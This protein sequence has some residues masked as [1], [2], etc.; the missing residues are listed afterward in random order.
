M[1]IL[2]EAM[3]DRI[4]HCASDSLCD[5]SKP[6]ISMSD[7]TVTQSDAIL[8][9]VMEEIQED[10]CNSDSNRKI[11]KSIEPPALNNCPATLAYPKGIQLVLSVASLCFSLFLA[12]LDQTIVSTTTPRIAAEFNSLSQISWIGTAYMLMSTTFQPLYGK[13]SD[14]FGRKK[15]LLFAMTMFLSGSVACG[16]S[17]SMTMLIVWRAIAGVGGGGLLTTSIVGLA[18]VVSPDRRDAYMGFFGG[19]WAFSA[20]I[21]PV[22][23]GVFVDHLNWRWAFYINLT[24]GLPTIPIFLLFA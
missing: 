18:D 7:Y 14:I 19:I 12:S 20:A 23:G 13:F 10:G 21:G 4:G 22:L 15:M 24:I 17:G 1:A 16:A 9:A 11:E 6:S 2:Y 5:E 3:K 8:S